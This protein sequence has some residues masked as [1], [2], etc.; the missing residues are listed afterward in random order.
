[1]FFDHKHAPA[2]TPD[3]ANLKITD[4]RIGDVLSVSGAGPDFS[5]LD[6]TLDRV[7]QLEAGSHRWFELSGAWRER[8]VFLELHRNDTVEVFGNFDGRK[9]TLDEVGLSEQDLADLDAR[10]NP[11]DF[12]DFEGKFW[13]YRFSRETGVFSGGNSTGTGFYAWQFQEQDGTRFMN[14]R[15]YKGEPF[16]ANIWVRTEPG[17]ITV[18]RGA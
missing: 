6:F 12:F 18:Y 2:S 11:S 13:L 5:D 16:Y 7:D 9:I 15:K 17:D 4:A 10:Q 14:I 1:M 8:R 3:L